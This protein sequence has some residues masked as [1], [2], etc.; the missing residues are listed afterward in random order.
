MRLSLVILSTLPLVVGIGAC[1]DDDDQ[2]TASARTTDAYCA[3]LNANQDDEGPTEAFFEEHPDP[4]L[5]D[6]AEG[7]PDIIAR[8]Q[9]TRDRLAAIRPSSELAEEHD[10]MVDRLDAVIASFETSLGAARAGDQDAYDAEER[11]NQDENVPALESAFQDLA[12][13]CG[14]E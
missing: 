1:G 4:T 11:R 2:T 12:D 13:A 7:L 9:D 8:A 5:E 14:A 3:D 10:A 6:W